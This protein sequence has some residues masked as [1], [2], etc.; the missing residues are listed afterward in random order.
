MN[1]KKCK[2]RCDC[3]MQKIGDDHFIKPDNG[4]F[5]PDQN[6][7]N[8]KGKGFKEFIFNCGEDAIASYSAIC[9]ICG[10]SNGVYFQYREINENIPPEQGFDRPGP[11]CCNKNCVN[12]KNDPISW[13]NE[14]E[15]V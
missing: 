15:L 14:K 2:E 13:I 10:E 7:E 8:C 1:D 11:Y 12:Y 9:P 6:C 5:D 4:Y 3:T